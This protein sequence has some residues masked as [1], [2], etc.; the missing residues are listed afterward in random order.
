MATPRR[1]A[2]RAKPVGCRE[3]AGT[4]TLP[5]D[6]PVLAANADEAIAEVELS[7]PGAV[8][9]EVIATVLLDFAEKLPAVTNDVVM[10]TSVVADA[11]K[12]GSVLPPRTAA[13]PVDAT[14]RG[15]KE[16]VDAARVISCATR[17]TGKH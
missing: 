12:V 1:P 8:D 9:V 17:W 10:V 11:V 5:L 16:A 3:T 4:A 2:N 14:D 15:V 7:E 13:L 6:F